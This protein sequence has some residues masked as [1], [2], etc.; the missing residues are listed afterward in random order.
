MR[1]RIISPMQW[2]VVHGGSAPIDV[3]L[4]DMI[5]P[6]LRHW[7]LAHWEL[8][9]LALFNQATYYNV[10]ERDKNLDLAVGNLKDWQ[11]PASDADD[12]EIEAFN[13]AMSRHQ[14]AIIAGDMEMEAI[15][16]YADEVTI[17]ATW[18]FA[19]KYLNAGLTT[20]RTLLNLPP[21]NSHRWPDIASSYA[22]CGVVLSTL[23]SFADADECRR[24]NNAIKHS[25][26]VDGGLTQFA[27]FAGKQ[28]STLNDLVLETQRYYFGVA[29]FVGATFEHCSNMI[30]AGNAGVQP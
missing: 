5:D 26:K 20:M 23:D 6:F 27:F 7:S 25:G 11:R 30:R 13:L 2:P 14:N 9:N 21:A 24:L 4:F 28:G 17:I 8:E 19:E 3:R 18:A 22:E 29:D 16:R 1:K 15:S 10:A 12:D